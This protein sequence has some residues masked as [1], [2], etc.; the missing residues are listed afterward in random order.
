MMC[1]SV[2]ADIKEFKVL[3]AIVRLD[4]VA[5][6]DVLGLPQSTPKIP[7]HNKAMLKVINAVSGELNITVSS[8]LAGDCLAAVHIE[9]SKGTEPP[10]P[11]A[12]KSL[13]AT[14]A[15]VIW[16]SRASMREVVS[17]MIISKSPC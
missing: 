1:P 14:V 4:S 6:V 15:G 2:L 5:V 10:S 12:A 8:D 11:L 16:H 3:K 9:A 13:A 7:S 17:A